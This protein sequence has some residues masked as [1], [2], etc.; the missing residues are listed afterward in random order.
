MIEFKRVNE[1][2]ILSLGYDYRNKRPKVQIIATKE[3]TEQIAKVFTEE[4]AELIGSS[5]QIWEFG[6]FKLTNAPD[7]P[8]GWT[9][10]R[11]RTIL[12]HKDRSW[13]MI[14]PE[15]EELGELARKALN[16]GN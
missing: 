9:D 4:F 16:V 14:V 10:T 13:H 15:I 7:H 8:Y 11:E 2:F 6:S 5:N 1:E 3:E 12:H